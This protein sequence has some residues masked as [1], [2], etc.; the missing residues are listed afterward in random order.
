MPKSTETANRHPEPASATC[1]SC[2][3]QLVW[4][5]GRVLREGIAGGKP[6]LELLTNNW[7]KVCPSC[8]SV[9]LQTRGGLLLPFLCADGIM[10]TT[11][12]G[13]QVA[14]DVSE[15]VLDFCGFRFT[16]SALLN[17][18]KFIEQEDDQRPEYATA[19]VE[20]AGKRYRKEPSARTARTFSYLVCKWGRGG[21]VW[22]NL[23][24]YHEAKLGDRLHQWLQE[25]NSARDAETAITPTVGKDDASEAAGIKGLGVSFASKHLPM[26]HPDRYAVLDN[27]LNA[28][29]G[30]APNAKGYALFMRQ[31]LRFQQRYHQLEPTPPR[32]T[33]GQLES[34][35]FMMVRQHVRSDSSEQPTLIA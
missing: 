8:H 18:T 4:I 3:Q 2:G 24:S 31:L 1:S 23:E 29:L 26:L 19:K 11:Q 35:I 27:V 10:R 33:V 6:E 7:Y 34:G 21:R 9:M 22:G 16:A 14:K 32:R 20:N 13:M 5:N 30:F 12:D 25:A 15:T 28:G 17:S